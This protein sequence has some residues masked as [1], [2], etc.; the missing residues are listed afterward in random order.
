MDQIILYSNNCAECVRAKVKLEN[1]NITFTEVND[2]NRIMDVATNIKRKQLPIM[3]YE[4]NYYSGG[5]V[6]VKI[7]EI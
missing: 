1:R 5:E 6:V 4:G 7:E 2:M 3:Y